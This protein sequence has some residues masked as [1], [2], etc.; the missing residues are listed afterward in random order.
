M[1]MFQEIKDAV[2]TKEAASFYGLKIGR[3]GM[4]CCPFHNDKHPSMKV[5]KRFHCFGC[6][7][8]GD[9]IN[10][11]QQMFNLDAKQAAF[12]LIDDFH[13][14]ID[15][16][17]KESRNEKNQRIRLQKEKERKERIR[18]AYIEELQRFRSKMAEIYRTLHDWE[19][20]YEPTKEQ[21][22]IGNIDERYICAINNKDPVDCIIEILDFGEDEEIYEEYK[23]REETIASYERKITATER[24]AGE[25]GGERTFSGRGPE[26]VVGKERQ[27]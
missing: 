7:A 16:K 3:G 15:T 26:R 13:L 17:R 6:G 14:N 19:L 5:D 8:D 11:V 9:V 23:R 2:S 25:R 4:A 10:F 1:N 20:D 18:A 24:R 12:K 22:D 21:W 27:R